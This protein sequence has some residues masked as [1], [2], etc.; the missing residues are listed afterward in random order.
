MKTERCSTENRIFLGNFESEVAFSKAYPY[1]YEARFEYDDNYRFNVFAKIDD[2]ENYVFENA[3]I[4]KD[5]GQLIKD[6]KEFLSELRELLCIEMEGM[7]AGECFVGFYENLQKAKEE[8]GFNTLRIGRYGDFCSVE[9]ADG[10]IIVNYFGNNKAS[11]FAIREEVRLY[12]SDLENKIQEDCMGYKYMKIFV[13]SLEDK[14][15]G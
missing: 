9:E 11:F 7:Y 2:F 6:Q 12:M 5:T 4:L 10:K 13:Q 1:F 3:A 14:L 15:A 8:M